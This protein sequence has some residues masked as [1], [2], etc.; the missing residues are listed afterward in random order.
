MIK[1]LITDLAGDKITLSQALTRSK[2][3]AFKINNDTLKNWIK[4]ESEGYVF[5]DELLPEYR[6]VYSEMNLIAQFTGGEERIIP[7]KIPEG[8]PKNVLDTIYFHQILE[9]ISIV[10]LQLAES[11]R[12]ENGRITLP[13]EMMEMIKSTL[14]K[15]LI[16]QITMVGG[17]IDKL[18]RKINTVHYHNIINQTKNKLLDI[19]LE[20]E[21]EFP[22]LENDY[23]MSDE[24]NNKA[25]NIITNNIYGGNSPINIATGNNNTQTNSI[26]IENINFDRLKE[27]NVEEKE[28]E[29]LKSIVSE[30]KDD[31]SKFPSKVMGWLSSVTSSLV[32]RGFYDNIP[33]ITEFA[34]SLIQ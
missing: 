25:N 4:K 13:N 17:V 22:N 30:S 19:L 29:E 31:K 3:I 6:K 28:I 23:I 5:D 1:E 10:E 12:P 20:L 32:A 24:N 7:F 14:P 16:M 21:A 27:L 26:S 8:T 15:P 33:Q 34:Q 11:G 2:I 9:S 18:Q